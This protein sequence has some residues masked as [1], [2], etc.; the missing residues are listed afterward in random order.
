MIQNLLS[1]P[2]MAMNE[3]DTPPLPPF[4]V[5]NTEQTYIVNGVNPFRVATTLVLL[6]EGITSNTKRDSLQITV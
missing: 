4:V 1:S 2:V 5:A 6:F 3:F